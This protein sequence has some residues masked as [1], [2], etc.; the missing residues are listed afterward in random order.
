VFMYQL[1]SLYIGQAAAMAI[2]NFGLVII[3]VLAFLRMNRWG[4]QEAF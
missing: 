4:R 2:I 1:K 3:I